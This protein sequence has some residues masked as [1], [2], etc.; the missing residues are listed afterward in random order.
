MSD[1][2]IRPLDRSQRKSLRVA[3]IGN[4]LEWFDWTLYGMFSFYLSANLFNN[5]DPTSAFLN[6][7]LTF[8]GGFLARPI[9]GWLFGGLGDRYGRKNALVLT[10]CLIAAASIGIAVLPTY[11]NVGATASILL[12][13][14]RLLQ[15]L[16]H[17]GETG[18]SFTYVAEIAPTERRGFWSSAVYV[19]VLCGV[20]AATGVAALLTSVLSAEAMMLWGWRVGFALGGILGIYALFLRR[21]AAESEAFE[22]QGAAHTGGA[23]PKLTGRQ[24]WIITRNIVMISAVVNAAYYTWVTF[25][26]SNA[27]SQGMDPAGAYRAALFAQIVCLAWLPVAGWLSDKL[28]RRFMV[29]AFGLGVVVI[30][31][32]VSW[33]VTDA[34]W[35]LFVA[36]LI[37][38][39]V[40]GLL[41]GMFPALVSEQVPTHARA[42]SVGWI[43]STVAAVFGGTAPYLYAWLNARDLGW[44]YDVYLVALGLVAWLGGYLIK[45][46]AKKPIEEIGME[47]H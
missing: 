9:G 24:L 23:R 44:V 20:I 3:A 1:T 25:A 26:A 16:A 12:L 45:E 33:M 28:G 47:N 41:A 39:F 27:I 13:V 17:G 34:P 40:W 30:A 37:C 35:T 11:A 14:L 46:T 19:S 8:A 31:F 6:T 43:T 15:G 42:T 4:A 7:L 32:P 38:L 22:K 36:Q 29:M 2:A 5:E 10:M 18:V 21:S